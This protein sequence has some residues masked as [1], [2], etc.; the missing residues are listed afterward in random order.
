[1]PALSRLFKSD[2]DAFSRLRR[3][4]SRFLLALGLPL[5]F[6]GFVVA[7]DLVVAIFGLQ[8][9]LAAQAFKIHLLLLPLLY[10]RYLASNLLFAADREVDN[11]RLSAVGA[12]FNI[13]INL[14]LIPAYAHIG[15]AVSAFIT[16]VIMLSIAMFY[17]I[18][19]GVSFNIGINGNKL[20]LSAALM[21]GLLHLL[22][23]PLYVSIPLGAIFYLILLLVF[24][25]GSIS[26]IRG[27]FKKLYR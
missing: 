14:A 10:M 25:V 9:I 4:C 17:A 23:M 11:L 26:E 22:S 8:Y 12:F 7:E 19:S 16:Q 6:G 2:R 21:A 13:A 24:R 1:M 20:I 27:L 18:R 5:A 3:D 15:A